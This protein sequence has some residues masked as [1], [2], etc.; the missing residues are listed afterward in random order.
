LK[1]IKLVFSKIKKIPLPVLIG[2]FVFISIHLLLVSKTFYV[3]SGNN[4][5]TT[6]AGY[7]D[8]ALHMTQISKFAFSNITNLS[9][10]I[11]YGEK[12]NYPFAINFLS[13]MFLRMTGDWTFSF[14]APALFF[15]FVNTLLAFWI[16][17]IFFQNKSKWAF[18]GLL[19]FFLGS[20]MGG[21]NYILD[22][23]NYNYSPFGFI[24][25]LTKGMATTVGRWDA[26][27][28]E[29][30]IG[31]GLPLSLGF[32]HQR[33]FFAGFFGFLVMFLLL[34]KGIRTE[35]TKY[36]IGA[37]L[38]LGFLPILHAHSFV[39]A[40]ISVFA[41]GITFLITNK[42]ENLK[43]IATVFV[44]GAIVSL[45]QLY[46]VFDIGA[47]TATTGFLEPRLGWMIN[48][49]RG[50][51]QF[52]INQQAT[53]FNFSYLKF[54]WV[55]FGVIL[56]AFFIFVLILLS[57]PKLF[58]RDNF[59]I[60][61]F[62]LTASLLFAIVQTIKFQPWDYDNNKLLV[63]FQFFSVPVIILMFKKLYEQKKKLG[64]A[65]LSIFLLFALFSGFIDLIPRLAINKNSLP[66]IFN[67]DSQKIA[68][69]IKINASEDE[70]ILTGTTHL[71]P[72][73]AL[74]GRSVL[75]GY[76]GWLWTRG[77]DYKKR[78]REVAEFYKNPSVSKDIILEYQPA[79][80]LF[81][82]YVVEDYS[83]DKKVFDDNF[84][85]VFESGDFILYKN[86]TFTK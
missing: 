50:A 5:H 82:P 40:L 24:E 11:F 23:N 86:S 47:K 36:Y 84:E 21:W 22:I 77:L 63:Y 56:P 79:L 27:W 9:E 30:N 3:D 37:G 85:K 61:F 66:I 10:P 42:K 83:A 6:I 78:L 52:P 20:G 35:K 17:N 57:K 67:S 62:A 71:N 58:G 15:A 14:L 46:Y 4:I 8:T 28:P 18:V 55:N 12:L 76:P 39:A 31:F 64:I 2:L 26:V 80:I 65:V 54:V 16:Y 70:I 51:A 44:I 81:D 38:A 1:I 25:G 33:A 75:V 69:Y 29:Q 53:I 13:A 45:P 7:G 73:N 74:A 59:L 72:V 60:I 32:I 68:E 43:K 41:L 34:L 48:S 19:V 49:A